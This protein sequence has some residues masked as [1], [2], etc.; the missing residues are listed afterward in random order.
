ML[1]SPLRLRVTGSITT[2]TQELSR[3]CARP[4]TLERGI[5][6]NDGSRDP[7]NTMADQTLAFSLLDQLVRVPWLRQRRVVSGEGHESGRVVGELN[8]KLF[9]TFTRF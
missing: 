1:F 5:M 9:F 4:G 3:Q 8:K 6:E 2:S 7:S